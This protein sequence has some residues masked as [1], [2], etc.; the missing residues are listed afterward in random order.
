MNYRPKQVMLGKYI[1]LR[2][3]YLK[4]IMDTKGSI[5]ELITL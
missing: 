1:L 2:T 5:K 3:N 4:T